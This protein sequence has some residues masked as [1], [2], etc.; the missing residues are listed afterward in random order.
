MALSCLPKVEL[1][2][3]IEGAVLPSLV[4]TLAKSNGYQF[5]LPQKWC[6]PGFKFS[7]PA[8]FIASIHDISAACLRTGDDYEVVCRA[9]AQSLHD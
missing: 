3:H 6:E 1:H 4:S 7:G 8:D 5:D 2:L 9:Y